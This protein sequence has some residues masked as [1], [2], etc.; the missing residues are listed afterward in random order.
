MDE[1]RFTL[2]ELLVVI[3]IIALLAGLLIPALS[4]SRAS[5][6]RS[7]CQ[8]NLRSIGQAMH[9]YA[10][11]IGGKMP[12]AAQMP[13]VDTLG[14]P[15]ICDVLADE[16]QNQKVFRCPSD[17][18]GY[19]QREGSSYEYNM[20]LAGRLIKDITERRLGNNTFVMF[21]YKP[22]HGKPGKPGSTNYLFIDGRVGDLRD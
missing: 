20:N 10:D 11:S 6:R 15:R 5:A 3:T 18:E 21:D 7:E 13:S 4:S 22:F 1:F 8:G 17:N 14:L 12:V 9:M 19:Y 16:A 2:I